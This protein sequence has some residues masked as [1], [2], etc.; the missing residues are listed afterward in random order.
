MAAS[1]GMCQRC[2]RSTARHVHH[3]TY[4]NL[5]HEP[6]SDLMPVCGSCHQAIHLAVS[7]QMAFPI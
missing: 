6:L 1:G 3:L 5:G 4:N 7:G 2:G